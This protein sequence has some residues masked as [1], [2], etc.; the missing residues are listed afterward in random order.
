MKYS[1]E[2]VERLSGETGFVPATLEKVLRLERL[3]D[4]VSRHPFLGSRLV[5]KGGTALNVFYAEAP[6]LSVDLDFNYVGAESRAEMERERPEVERA[7]EQI[8]RGDEYRVQRAAE[9]HAGRKFY[10]GYLNAL[11]SPDRIEVDLNYMFR[12]PLATP[13]LRDGWR[14]DPDMPCRAM[15]AGFEEVM[16]GKIVALLDRAA[17][18]DLYDAAAFLDN[19]PEHDPTLLRCLCVGLSG[20]LPRALSEYD[21][22]RLDVFDQEQLEPGLVPFLRAGTAPLVEELREPVR[23]FLA[24]LLNLSAE[25]KRYV[26]GLQWGELGPDLIAG[27]DRDLAE[28]LRRHPAILWKVENARR[29]PRR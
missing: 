29:R 21:S 9:A 20:V 8:V 10:L 12:V 28:R 25:E 15:M 4:Q 24:A 22:S 11:G 27:S 7:V 14:P 23:R 16:A 6:R 26:E 17:P 1:R 5:L 19:P 2:Y 3:L 18:R 13:V